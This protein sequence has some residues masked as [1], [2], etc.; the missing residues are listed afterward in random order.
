MPEP[1]EEIMTRFRRT[2]IRLLAVVWAFPTTFLGIIFLALALLTGGRAK[3]VG[4]VLEAH[5][6]M[7]ATLLNRGPLARTRI[8]AVTLGHVIL[9]SSQ[10]VL[11][12]S[13]THE[14]THVRQCERWGPL[15]LPAYAVESVWAALRGRDPY[16]DNRFE[17]EA[18]SG[19]RV[20][21]DACERP[22]SVVN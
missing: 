18:L 5:G 20:A 4:G 6:G 15:F 9:A 7:I 11:E 13:R 2:A 10:S 1:F 16:R 22:K 8:A 17:R 12:E 19:E 21:T 3:N 14:R